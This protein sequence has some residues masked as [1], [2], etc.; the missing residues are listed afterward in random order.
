MKKLYILVI[1]I[2]LFAI[3]VGAQSAQFVPPPIWEGNNNTGFGGAVG[4]SYMV[5]QPNNSSS[6]IEFG[7]SK[8]E[9]DFFDDVFVLYL[10]I[11][12]TGRNIIDSS[13]D[14]DLDEYRIAISNS[15]SFGYGSNIKF[16]PGFAATYAVVID[17]SFAGLYEIP[18]TGLVGSGELNFI[19]TIN[20]T[21]TSGSQNGF[22]FS[23][24]Y[25]DLNLVYAQGFFFV[26]TYV[27]RTAFSS[28]EGYG[29]GITLGTQGGDEINFT[30]Y[31][32]FQ[33]PPDSKY[34]IF[35]FELTNNTSVIINTST[36]YSEVV[37]DINGVEI[38]VSST[39]GDVT[40]TDGKIYSTGTHILFNFNN[41]VVFRSFI[42]DLPIGN[43]IDLTL[44]DTSNNPLPM[45]IPIEG[46]ESTTTQGWPNSLTCDYI[47]RVS[48]EYLNTDFTINK[49]KLLNENVL[50]SNL[51]EKEPIKLYPNPV[52]DILN[53]EGL[54]FTHNIIIYDILGKEVFKDKVYKSV[55]LSSLNKGLYFLKLSDTSGN[56]ITKKIIKL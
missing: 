18:P 45:N 9:G 36:T 37:Q 1:L 54:Q 32:S 4:E 5:I 15:N 27:S 24:N 8:P 34:I 53:I 16:P 2:C 25:S 50:S 41:A 30:C 3:Q 11:G 28:D 20:S 43:S 33:G 21:L 35:D 22:D 14:D 29:E 49:V 6:T 23:V 46:L 26:G 48:L 55:D 39:N 52:K 38:T 40:I 7:F 19:N 56:N 44:Y 17:T 13:V 31:Q 12:S 47:S 42:H 51:V 10:D